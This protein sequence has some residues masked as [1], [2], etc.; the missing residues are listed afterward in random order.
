MEQILEEADEF[1]I[2]NISNK[3]VPALS[4]YLSIWEVL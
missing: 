2:D 1:E 3:S 4:Y